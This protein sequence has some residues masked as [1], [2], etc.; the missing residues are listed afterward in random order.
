MFSRYS[1]FQGAVQRPLLMTQHTTRRSLRVNPL[2]LNLPNL[3]TCRLVPPIPAWGPSFTVRKRAQPARKGAGRVQI[4]ANRRVTEASRRNRYG[5]SWK[6]IRPLQWARQR[7]RS[8]ATTTENPVAGGNWLT[9]S[10]NKLLDFYRH[11]KPGNDDLCGRAN[12]SVKS[13]RSGLT[14]SLVRS[15]LRQ[16]YG[17]ILEK[18]NHTGRKR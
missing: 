9:S 12:F 18:R 17:G 6:M 4:Y 2:P 7:E 15:F 5:L 13:P 16:D 11:E 1:H 3:P 14:Q 10:K 8:V